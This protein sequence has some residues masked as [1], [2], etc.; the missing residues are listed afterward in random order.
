MKMEI[1]KLAMKISEENYFGEHRRGAGRED[2][3]KGR[4]KKKAKFI[5]VKRICCYLVEINKKFAAVS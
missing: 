3:R 1:Q 4:K 5:P 2:E